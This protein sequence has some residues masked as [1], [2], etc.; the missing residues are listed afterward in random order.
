MSPPPPV[1][2]I[3]KESHRIELK[4]Q[5]PASNQYESIVGTSENIRKEERKGKRKGNAKHQTGDVNGY[6]VYR[7]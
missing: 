7:Q 5:C 2:Y 4:K 6:V 3:P 1:Y